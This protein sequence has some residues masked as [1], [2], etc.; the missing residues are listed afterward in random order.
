MVAG[1]AISRPRIQLARMDMR[2]AYIQATQVQTN[3]NY[4]SGV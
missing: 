3:T 4:F 1:H 2:E